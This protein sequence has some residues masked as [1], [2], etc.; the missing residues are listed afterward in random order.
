MLIEI[1]PPL[2]NGQPW[3]AESL[4]LRPERLWHDEVR[5]VKEYG[6]LPGMEKRWLTGWPVPFYEHRFPILS[7]FMPSWL[8]YDMRL[9]WA[10]GIDDSGYAPRP[11]MRRTA[12]G[13]QIALENM[14]KDYSAA[15]GFQARRSGVPRLGRIGRSLRTRTLAR[16]LG[17]DARGNCVSRSLYARSVAADRRLLAGRREPHA[18]SDSQCARMAARFRVRRFAPFAASGRRSIYDPFCTG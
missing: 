13:E 15:Y 10:L 14:R 17:A 11:K 3:N 5:V 4:R 12:A 18:H 2:L 9:D 8:P 6:G 1:L 16:G 7:R